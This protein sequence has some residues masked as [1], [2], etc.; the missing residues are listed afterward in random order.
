MQYVVMQY[1]VMQYVL[2]Q[3]RSIVVNDQPHIKRSLC[4]T[5]IALLGRLVKIQTQ[6]SM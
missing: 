4:R 3:S 2:L 5:Q 6:S 1:V